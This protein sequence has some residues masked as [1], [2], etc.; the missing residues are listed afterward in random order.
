MATTFDAPTGESCLARRD[1][2]NSPLQ[3]L[4][5]LN[6][7]MFMEAAQALAKA[8]ALETTDASKRIQTMFRRCATRPAQDEEIRAFR[9]FLDKQTSSGCSEEA[10]WTSLAR[11]ILNLDEVITHP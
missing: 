4:T 11:A 5:L 3:A 6:D 7:S 8:S 10:A 9:S 2:S 1:V